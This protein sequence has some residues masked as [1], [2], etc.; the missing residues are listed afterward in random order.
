MPVI[1]KRGRAKLKKFRSAEVGRVT[2][3]S[4]SGSAVFAYMSVD[5]TAQIFFT[6][7]A[8]PVKGAETDKRN[9]EHNLRRNDSIF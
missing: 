5:I 7:G 8:S 4:Q 2:L 6:Q 1:N 3:L 9:D